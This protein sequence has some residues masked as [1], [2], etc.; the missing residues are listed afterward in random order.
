M[1]SSSSF[2]FVIRDGVDTDL[3]DCLSLEHT[4]ETD[5]VWQMS[6]QQENTGW[7]VAFRT[8]RLP[9][10]IEFEYPADETRL[11]LALP[12]EICFLVAAG[13]DEPDMLGY[14]T[15]RPDPVY[16]NAL[17]QDIVVSRPFRRRGVGT[18]LLSVARRW[19]LEHGALRLLVEVQTRNF[20]A[21]QFCQAG[22]LTFCGFNDQYFP[23]HEIAV[24]FGQSLRQS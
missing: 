8:E 14:L 1:S 17:V 15:M 23:K 19:A 4:C 9:R 16:G 5:Y 21:I 10:T 18:R 13:K 3:A 22:G 11:E 6:M 2:S 12:S 20:P 7:R 24:F